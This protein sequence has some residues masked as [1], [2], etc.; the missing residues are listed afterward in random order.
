MPIRTRLLEMPDTASFSDPS[1]DPDPPHVSIPV[2][3]LSNRLDTWGNPSLAIRCSHHRLGENS[4]QKSRIS[5]K[6]K[7]W[8]KVLTLPSPPGRGFG[9]E[10]M[11]T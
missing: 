6:E 3:T 4:S 5:V 11:V 9:D 7:L 8:I 1:P 2:N 10:F